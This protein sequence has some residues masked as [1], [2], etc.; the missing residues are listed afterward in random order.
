MDGWPRP[1]FCIDA[2]T[3]PFQQGSKVRWSQAFQNPDTL[4]TILADREIEDC[5]D[6]LVAMDRSWNNGRHCAEALRSMSENLQKQFDSNALGRSPKTA[7]AQARNRGLSAP[8][9]ADGSFEGGAASS[10]G[11]TPTRKRRRLDSQEHRGP[12]EAR[13]E[14]HSASDSRPGFFQ[15]PRLEQDFDPDLGIWS[16]FDDG[17]GLPNLDYS[18]SQ[19]GMG[20]PALPDVDSSEYLR[21]PLANDLYANNPGAFGNIG[22]E[23]MANGAGYMNDW[24]SWSTPRF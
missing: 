1:V 4:L 17:A 22:W 16:S 12:A 24:N 14:L 9:N 8:S 18:T 21:L 10:K 3:V 6:Q 23:A 11:D 15:Q 19:F 13:N 20:T 5:I 7:P 2:E